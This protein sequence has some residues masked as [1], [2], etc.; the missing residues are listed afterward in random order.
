MLATVAPAQVK[1]GLDRMVGTGATPFLRATLFGGRV[2]KTGAL[3]PIAAAHRSSLLSPVPE[4]R[5]PSP[6]LPLL[7]AWTEFHALA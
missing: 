3:A 5:W 7:H 2:E 4:H 1:R 6:T